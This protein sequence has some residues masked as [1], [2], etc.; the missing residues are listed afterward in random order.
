MTT[1]GTSTESDHDRLASHRLVVKAGTNVLT[2]SGTKLD[3][4]AMSEIVA[5]MAQV[6]AAGAQVILV[7]SGAIAAGREVISKSRDTKGVGLGQMLAAVG[8]S[9]L[10]HAYQEMFA[11]HGIVVAQALLTHQDVE[12]RRGYLNVRNTLEALLAN[13]VVPIVNENDVV[14]TEEISQERFGD[15]DTLSALVANIIDAD[16]LLILSDVAGLYTADPNRDKT[17]TL[18][19]RVDEVD[20]MTMALA[21]EHR[22]STT[23]G[24]MGSKLRA[25]QLAMSTGVNVVIARGH[26]PNVIID[27]ASGEARGTLFPATATHVESR[28]RWLLSG[29]AD[30]GGVVVVDEGA[31]AAVRK[32]SRSL[33]PA[34]VRE[35][36]GVFKRGD[37]VAVA[38]PNGQR[39]AV[40]V[41]NYDSDELTSIKGAKSSDIAGLLGHHFGDEA[42]HRNNMA[43]L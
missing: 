13:G 1:S 32:Q 19:P 25:A 41:T 5:Q 33:L 27:V 6:Q 28:K 42:I 23:R 35:V 31:V 2:S 16:L 24:G 29:T 18:I 17:A 30:S 14:D 38:E 9:R 20:A 26:E 15:N 4:K 7:T 37:V 43:V 22:S 11:E 39:I 3:R 21:E 10:M 8:Q 34:G 40:G 36:T 12:G